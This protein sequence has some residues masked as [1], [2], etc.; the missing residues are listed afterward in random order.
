[1]SKILEL[2]EKRAKAWETAKAFLDAKRNAD[3]F[4]SA[5]DAATYEKMEADVQNLTTEIERLARQQAIDDK[6]A[7]ATSKPITMQ[8]NAQMETERAK[9]F[10]ERTA[11]KNA[12][13]DA[14]RT[15]FRKISDV[16]QEG[17]DADG[18]YLVP[19][20]YDNRLI[21]VLKE[22]NI[23]RGL[24]TRITTSGEHKINIAATTPAALW[25]EEGGALTFGDAT[26]DQKFV[27]SHKLHVAIKVTEELL[28]DSA[29]DLEKYIIT[30]FGKALANA[31]EDAFLNGDGKGKPYG[32][33]DA[34]TGGESAG[35][36]S[37]DIKAD[38]IFDLIYKLKRPYRKGASFIMN[39]K[40]I[41]QIR[42]LKDNNGQFLWQPSLVAGEPDQIAGYTV[43][44]SAYAPENAIAFGDYSYYN[45]ADRGARSF[46][47][48]N[49]LFAGNGMVGFVAKERVDGLLL[50]PEA[51]QIMNLK[52]ASTT[53]T[54]A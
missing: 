28:Y 10:R 19:V 43:R 29:F 13:V 32:I 8:P 37:A 30:Q 20:E 49:E 52:T 27:D 11:Y 35:T 50:L 39:D 4:V 23:M 45:I 51:V 34:A 3:G 41:A 15:N 48:L 7:Q 46:K 1:M 40:T 21:E 12:M 42:K 17:V 54:K 33:F 25:V 22:E 2:T 6:L 36:L 31:E 5:E 16:L 38:D 47:T 24:A 18:G 44:T 53:T 14:L 26:F 9:P